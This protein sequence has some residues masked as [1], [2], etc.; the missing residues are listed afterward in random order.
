MDA[1][2]VESFRSRKK[3]RSNSHEKKHKTGGAFIAD[4]HTWDL[5]Y[6]RKTPVVDDRDRIA[7]YGSGFSKL[8]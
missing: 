7:R 1:S 3:N 2:G 6:G 4:S 5:K 8:L